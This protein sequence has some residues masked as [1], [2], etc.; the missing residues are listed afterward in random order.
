MIVSVETANPSAWQPALA[1]EEKRIE[2]VFKAEENQ[3][4][5]A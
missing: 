2:L 1:R 5:D 4:P 3:E